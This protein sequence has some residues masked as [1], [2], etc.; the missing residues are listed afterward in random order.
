[1][2]AAGAITFLASSSEAAIALLGVVPGIAMWR[3]REKRQLAWWAALL[4]IVM[5][6]LIMKAP[7]WGPDRPCIGP[8]WRHGLARS[9]LITQ[10]VSHIGEWWFWG[11]DYTA[12]RMPYTVPK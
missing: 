3:F 7:V 1:L 9:E 5:L 12:H 2:L 11:T 10:A 4:A 6:H 8:G